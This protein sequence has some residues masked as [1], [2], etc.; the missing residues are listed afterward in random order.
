MLVH[1]DENVQ[2]QLASLR[3]RGFSHYCRGT[4]DPSLLQQFGEWAAL[5]IAEDI[6]VHASKDARPGMTGRPILIGKGFSGAALLTCVSMA[7]TEHFPSLR[8]GSMYARK[9][10][11]DHHNGKLPF[12]SYNVKMDNESNVIYFVDDFVDYG[13]T[14]FSIFGFRTKREDGKK[15][16][17]FNETSELSGKVA[18]PHIMKF[19]RVSTCMYGGNWCARIRPL[20]MV[21]PAG[22]YQMD[23]GYSDT[24]KY[25][26]EERRFKI[27]LHY[28]KL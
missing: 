11:E 15:I 16:W 24:D 2:G 3:E 6:E 8:H 18:L 13:S 19:T 10:E 21:L 22:M 26:P 28:F 20:D 23:N 14:L 1:I 4:M 27:P 12:E 5:H 25:D 9:D 17:E 7:L